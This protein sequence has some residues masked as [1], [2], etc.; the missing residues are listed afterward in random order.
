MFYFRLLLLILI[1]KS[2][3]SL[4]RDISILIFHLPCEEGIDGDIEN[5]VIKKKL[6]A[7]TDV[8]KIINTNDLPNKGL[9]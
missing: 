6:S 8:T 9:V 1:G 4:E 3:S 2:L 7:E 5:N